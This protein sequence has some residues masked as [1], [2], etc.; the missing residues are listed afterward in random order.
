MEVTR[1]DWKLCALSLLARQTNA[2]L[3]SWLVQ[4]AITTHQPRKSRTVLPAPV[5]AVINRM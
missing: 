5:R 2:A 1:Y 4:A 3:Y